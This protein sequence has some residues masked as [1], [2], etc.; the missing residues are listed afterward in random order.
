MSSPDGH[1]WSEAV[2]AIARVER[3]GTDQHI[4]IIKTISLIEFLGKPFDIRAS[5]SLLQRSF[6]EV[7][8]TAIL[9]DLDAWSSIVYRKHKK[10]WSL[11]SG[12]DLDL[13]LEIEKSI[14]ELGDNYLTIAQ[15]IPPISPIVA[16]KHYFTTGSLRWFDIKFTD[17][18]SLN[19]SLDS[20]KKDKS[21]G[22]FYIVLYDHQEISSQRSEFGILF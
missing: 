2:E 7:D 5:E 10:A 8:L 22:T 16:K 1:F 12:S 14:D 20:Q 21:I 6:P 13:N 3:Q 19:K 18:K 11:F 4:Q 15:S 17:I 9:K